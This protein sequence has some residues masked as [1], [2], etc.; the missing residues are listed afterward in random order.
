MTRNLT[1]FSNFTLLIVEYLK[2]FLTDINAAA[3]KYKTEV[4]IERIHKFYINLHKMI[5][6]RG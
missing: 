5:E 2:R 4:C 3:I 6:S 1:S